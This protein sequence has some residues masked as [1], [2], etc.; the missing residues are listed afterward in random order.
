MLALAEERRR[1]V[2]RAEI[3]EILGVKPKAADKVM[4][5]NS[6]GQSSLRRPHICAVV[7][8]ARGRFA[9]SILRRRSFLALAPW[10]FSDT[11]S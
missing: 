5:R 8:W 4:S 6:A 11:R 1:D 3:I 7:L 9:S 2:G 10:M